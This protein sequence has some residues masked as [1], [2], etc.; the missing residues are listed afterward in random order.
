[1]LSCCCQQNKTGT[2]LR[3]SISFERYR[4]V[5]I[6]ISGTFKTL[7]ETAE[8]LEAL[9]EFLKTWNIFHEYDIGLA[10]LHEVCKVGKE[11]QP[12]IRPLRSPGCV[13]FRKGLTG[14]ASAEQDGVRP[15]CIHEGVDVTRGD[16]ADVRKFKMD[17]GKIDLKGTL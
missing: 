11:R 13:L 15:L 2:A 12:V 1:M 10:P 9:V 3:Y 14:C 17:S 5:I 16:F 8:R 7:E 6:L 4:L